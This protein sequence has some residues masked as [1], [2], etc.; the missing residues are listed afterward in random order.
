MSQEYFGMTEPYWEKHFSWYNSRLKEK[1][2]QGILD[3]VE[4][5]VVVAVIEGIAESWVIYGEMRM[6]RL[7]VEGEEK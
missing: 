2:V 7:K 5:I 1:H 3:A 4:V 6:V